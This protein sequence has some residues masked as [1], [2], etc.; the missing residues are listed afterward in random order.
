MINNESKILKL[1]I[2]LFTTHKLS[3][4]KLMVPVELDFANATFDEDS[5]TMCVHRETLEEVVER[6]PRTSCSIRFC[7]R[8]LTKH[9]FISDI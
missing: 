4:S 8:I 3:S 5:K 9:Y 6:Q 1:A 2:L 7:C